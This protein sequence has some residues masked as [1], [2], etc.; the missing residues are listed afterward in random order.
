M[1]T[2]GALET[3]DRAAAPVAAGPSRRMRAERDRRAFVALMLVASTIGTAKGFLFARLLDV[4]AFGLYG[5][6]LLVVQFSLFITTWGVL[7]ALTFRLPEAYGR[8]DKW[9]GR[10]IDNAFASV[11]ATTAATVAAFLALLQ[12]VP[13]R[14][15]YKIALSLGGLGALLY[16]PLEYLLLVL[17]VQRRVLPLGLTYLV[18]STCAVAL[19]TVGAVVAGFEGVVAGEIIAMA[20]AVY[21]ASGRWLTTLRPRI[22]NPRW[23]L[24]LMRVGLPLAFANLLVACTFTVDRFFVAAALPA[25]LGQY[26][27][28]SLV[29]T[30]WIAVIGIAGQMTMPQLLFDYGAGLHLLGLRRKALSLMLLGL[31]AGLASVIALIVSAPLIEQLFP[32][33]ASGVHILPILDLGGTFGFIS[34]YG[35]LLQKLRPLLATA[36]AAIGAGVQIVGGFVLLMSHPTLEGFAWLFVA[37]QAVTAL[38]MLLGTEWQIRRTLADPGK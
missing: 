4:E 15:D 18:R 24:S 31:A 2:H 27:F 38:G 29:V 10:E 21:F 35:F 8:K 37:A 26:I 11:L 34:F 25:E 19:G 13:L 16:T 3:E 6:V 32:R 7:N 9:V 1:G 5:L 17:R 23:V 28:G 36:A 20:L 22:P 33:Y 14:V 12:V 30:V